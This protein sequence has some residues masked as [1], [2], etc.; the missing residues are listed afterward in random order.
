MLTA[1]AVLTGFALAFGLAAVLRVRHGRGRS[2][3]M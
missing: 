2:A 3:R 1:A